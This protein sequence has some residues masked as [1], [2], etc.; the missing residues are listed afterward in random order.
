[1]TGAAERADE[2]VDDVVG[3]VVGRLR[4]VRVIQR[5]MPRS[6]WASTRLMKSL[7][8]AKRQHP[9][10]RRHLWQHPLEGLEV[11]AHLLAEH[12]VD[13][14]D[15]AR[16]ARASRRG[17]RCSDDR[18]ASSSCASSAVGSTSASTTCAQRRPA[19]RSMTRPD[20]RRAAWRALRP[21]C[22]R[23]A[24]SSSSLEPKW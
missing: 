7:A 21:R 20:T 18:R 2:E 19:A 11:A 4:G 8:N 17:S 13:D 16:V 23:I 6:G 10:V 9:D 22:S 3:H 12:V 15:A 1:M 14:R 24:R 5:R